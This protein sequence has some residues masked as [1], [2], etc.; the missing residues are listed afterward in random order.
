MPSTWHLRSVGASCSSQPSVA[1]TQPSLHGFGSGFCGPSYPAVEHGGDCGTSR[2]EWAAED[3]KPNKRQALPSPSN[4]CSAPAE[5]YPVGL[6]LGPANLPIGA[7]FAHA[8]QSAAPPLQCRPVQ[9]PPVR[10]PP[11]RCPPV[12]CPPVRCPPVQCPPVDM[13]QYP[14]TSVAI[15][16]QAPQVLQVASS[17]EQ[18]YHETTAQVVDNG[19][20]LPGS[21]GAV[22]AASSGSLGVDTAIQESASGLEQYATRAG[23]PAACFPFDQHAGGDEA[24]AALFPVEEP[25]AVELRP[26]TAPPASANA[27]EKLSHLCGLYSRT[28]RWRPSQRISSPARSQTH[29]THS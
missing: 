1:G 5:R 6:V 8:V 25:T 11:V 28:L 19:G 7:Q 23:A 2:M 13:G 18:W 10:C 14:P 24:H 29:P 3:M 4:G 12:Q 26:D 16:A 17:D 27:V 22:E 9:C 21:A 20:A 15:A